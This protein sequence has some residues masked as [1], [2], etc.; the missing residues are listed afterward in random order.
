MQACAVQTGGPKMWKLPTELPTSVADGARRYSGLVV[1]GS[2]VEMR[3][4]KV[5]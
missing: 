5:V 2:K 3:G 1:E 4:F